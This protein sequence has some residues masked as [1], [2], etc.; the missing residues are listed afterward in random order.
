LNRYAVCRQVDGSRLEPAQMMD[1]EEF[2]KWILR[3]KDQGREVVVCYEAGFL[4]FVLARWLKSRGM[5]CLVMAPIRL[6]EGN[7]RV[8]TD[9][10]NAR[11]IAGRLDRYLAGN[12]RAM[13]VCRIPSEQEE[14]DR[15][16]TRQRQ[17]LLEHSQGLKAQGR[18]LLW[19]FGYLEEGRWCWWEEPYWSGMAKRVRA[20][21]LKR[22][23][24]LRAVIQELSKQVEGLE[25]ELF[26]QSKRVLSGGLSKLPLGTG[27]LSMLVLTREVMSW[28][29]FGNRRQVGCFSGL[30]PSEASTGK[31][32]RRGSVTKVGNPRVRM[33][34]VE[35]AWRWVR[36]QPNYHA[37]QR[38]KPVLSKPGAGSPARKKAI[39]AL[40]RV[41]AIDLWRLATG[42]TT[43]QNLGLV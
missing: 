14:L 1:P 31:S 13:T 39:V 15:E 2:R 32:T 42:Q 40:A 20:T 16:E 10:L 43:L 12:Q 8:E 9:K 23:G 5:E 35:M 21:I 38:W 19:E 27:W 37:L 11:D 3:Q 41:L 4:G 22:L 30:V 34:L 24:R 29:R 26:E 25:K 7:S 18:S 6:D 33:V 17:Q 36:L 28:Q